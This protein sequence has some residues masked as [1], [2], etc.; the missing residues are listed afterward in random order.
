MRF[1]DPRSDHEIHGLGGLVH[2]LK[3]LSPHRSVT[4]F[5]GS[6]SGYGGLWV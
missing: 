5:H 1:H 3:T 2:G 4:G 6:G